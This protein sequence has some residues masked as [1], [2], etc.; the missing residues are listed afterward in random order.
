[1]SLKSKVIEALMTVIDPELRQDVV[2]LQIVRD[3]EV[4]EKTGRVSLTFRPTTYFC[5][6]GIQL[7]LMVKQALKKV[8]GVKEIDIK[9]VDFVWANQAMEYL[10]A[11]DEKEVSEEEKK[12]NNQSE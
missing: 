5:P 8:E 4:D 12:D 9:V 11:L 6:I 10:K 2:K 7:A 3:I 1:M